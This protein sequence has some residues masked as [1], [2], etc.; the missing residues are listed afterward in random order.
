M[1]ERTSRD[2]FPWTLAFRIGVIVLLGSPL[3]AFVWETLNRLLAGTVEPSRLLLL[4]P[5]GFLLYLLLRYTARAV[6]AW[7]GVAG[8]HSDSPS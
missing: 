2:R 3:V 5:I 4:I 8:S 6:Q 7:D 1:A